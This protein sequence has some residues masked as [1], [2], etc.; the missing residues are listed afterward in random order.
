M[1]GASILRCEQDLPGNVLFGQKMSTAGNLE[2]LALVALVKSL[3]L[4]NKTDNL[5]AALSSYP[6]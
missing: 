5:G 1:L 2:F 4:V 3:K 6:Q